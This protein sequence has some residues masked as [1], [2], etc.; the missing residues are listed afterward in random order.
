[1]YLFD[2]GAGWFVLKGMLLIQLDQLAEA[3]NAFDVAL[4]I[5]STNV[6]AICAKVGIMSKFSK[7]RSEMLSCINNVSLLKKDNFNIYI[8]IRN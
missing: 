3:L 8:G 7:S 1:M 5:D 4:Q 2:L 6:T